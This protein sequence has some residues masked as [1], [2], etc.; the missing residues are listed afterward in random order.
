MRLTEIAQEMDIPMFSASRLVDSLVKVKMIKKVQEVTERRSIAVSLEP[1]GVELIKDIEEKS[2]NRVIKN[3]SNFSDA[4]FDLMVQV[5]EKL[6]T[7]L[8]VS[9]K[10]KQGT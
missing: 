7:I 5:V 4:D 8:E 10:V 3:F 1:A 2:Y 6:H 9:E